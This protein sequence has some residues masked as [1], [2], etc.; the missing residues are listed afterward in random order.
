MNDKTRTAASFRS[1][2]EDFESKS[3]WDMI[4]KEL[5]ESTEPLSAAEEREAFRD[6]VHAA[7]MGDNCRRH[8]IRER[9]F[10]ANM[11]LAY[12]Y[13]K[14]VAQRRRAAYGEYASGL[15]DLVHVAYLAICKTIDKFNVDSGNR[16]STYAITAIRNAI[17]EADG[18]RKRHEQ[19]VGRMER[20]DDS[21]E[22]YVSWRWLEQQGDSDPISA[23][24]D[25]KGW[26]EWLVA[27]M[28]SLSPRECDVLAAKFGAGGEQVSPRRHCAQIWHLEGAREP[29][30]EGRDRKAPPA[31]RS[32]AATRGGRAGARSPPGRGGEEENHG[33][34]GMHCR[35]V[36][37]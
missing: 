3:E 30:S 24:A 7:S 21:N 33:R 27:A 28:R 6:M 18:I 23:A 29:D 11:R 13:A 16:F 31:R 9:I 19:G 8:A 34:H 17:N 37:S 15:L 36:R 14:G 26:R 12:A 32:V 5:S 25:S 4:L 20:L 1:A 10:K 35:G 22:Q 2:P